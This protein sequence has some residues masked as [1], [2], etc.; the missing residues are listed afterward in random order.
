V[1]I[2][3]ARQNSFRGTAFWRCRRRA[4]LRHY[5]RE[6][7]Y[8][9]HLHDFVD[10]ASGSMVIALVVFGGAVARG[11]FHDLPGGRPCGSGGYLRRSPPS[12]CSVLEGQAA[13]ARALRPVV[14][15]HPRHRLVYYLAY[16]INEAR[17]PGADTLWSNVGFVVLLSYWF[18]GSARRRYRQLDEK[19]EE[20]E[21]GRC[22]RSR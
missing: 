2:V 4:G 7:D 18:M 6:H 19:R 3:Y 16:A 15:R 14:F 5:E 22:G 20:E 8:H 13:V 10:R 12:D 21:A 11:L 1:F 9:G 17:F